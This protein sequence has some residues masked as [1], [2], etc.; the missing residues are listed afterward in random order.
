M[1]LAEAKEAF[2]A[3][4][5]TDKDQR[6]EAANLIAQACVK[7][8]DEEFTYVGK[9]L[10][11]GLV[12][13]VEGAR[14]G[15][16]VALGLSLRKLSLDATSVSALT[17]RD[18][19]LDALHRLYDLECLPAT[20]RPLKI[21]HPGGD[22]REL[23]LA[24]L[25]A[26]GS[27]I[28]ALVD[29]QHVLLPSL[30]LDG[31][32]S[33]LALIAEQEPKSL[34]EA[35]GR[36]ACE[37]VTR[38]VPDRQAFRSGT[39]S[40]DA[41]VRYWKRRQR[42][43]HPTTDALALVLHCRLR[44]GLQA[45][46]AD[47]A[48]W[49]SEPP[50]C[51]RDL[52]QSYVRPM[53]EDLVHTDPNLV[54]H[55]LAL[56][57]VDSVRCVVSSSERSA[58][59]KRPLRG[60]NHPAAWVHFYEHIV[61]PM[62]LCHTQYEFVIL[63][64]RL[65]VLALTQAAS[66]LTCQ[67]QDWGGLFARAEWNERLWN[68]PLRYKKHAAVI[69]PLMG[70]L[71]DAL[72]ELLRASHPLGTSLAVALLCSALSS[73]SGRA[74]RPP[75]IVLE[76][77]VSQ[78]KATEIDPIAKLAV[79]SHSMDLLLQLLST[80]VLGTHHRSNLEEFEKIGT[81]LDAV[82]EELSRAPHPSS[83]RER[84]EKMLIET[85]GMIASS[86]GIS[87]NSA[88]AD[89]LP[90]LRRLLQCLQKS[91]QHEPTKAFQACLAHLDG[92]G[93][94]QDADETVT[95][96]LALILLTTLT[97]LLW[98]S[99]SVPFNRTSQGRPDHPEKEIIIQSAESLSRFLEKK[100]AADHIESEQYIDLVHTCLRLLRLDDHGIRKLV[101]AVFGAALTLS[102][103]VASL[104]GPVLTELPGLDQNETSAEGESL[105]SCS[106][107][108]D[109]MISADAHSTE[110]TAS[111]V[112]WEARTEIPDLGADM[113]LDLDQEDPAVLTAYDKTL[114][115]A[116]GPMFSNQ[117][118][119]RPRADGQNTRSNIQYCQRVL[120]LIQVT[121]Q[122]QIRST[123]I[124]PILLLDMLSALN[125][126]TDY[127]EETYGPSS[128]LYQ[129]LVRNV[130][131]GM[132]R[133][134]AVG[135][136]GTPTHDDVFLDAF[137][138]LLRESV[139]MATLR[140]AQIRFPDHLPATLHAGI[141]LA[142]RTN[143]PNGA[144]L[145]AS[146]VA[147]ELIQPL[148]AHYRAARG[149]VTATLGKRSTGSVPLS[150]FLAFAQDLATRSPAVFTTPIIEALR[151]LLTSEL[152][153]QDATAPRLRAHAVLECWAVVLHLASA[154]PTAV[155]VDLEQRLNL[156]ELWICY[157]AQFPTIGSGQRKA[158]KIIHPFLQRLTK[159]ME[160][161]RARPVDPKLNAQ[162]YRLYHLAV[163]KLAV[164]EH[165][166]AEFLRQ[167]QQILALLSMEE[168]PHAPA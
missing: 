32:L 23:A 13:S 73:P 85:A 100:T 52:L 144:A 25:Y 103:D 75:R 131:G 81:L 51:S 117:L 67:T 151:A 66:T 12:S 46:E 130:L 138:I 165:S 135:Q 167:R 19:L 148:F 56:L 123:R 55:A 108:I 142:L 6:C 84:I 18:L 38:L 163:E 147:V 107:S 10:V 37:A 137:R 160:T 11:H 105:T 4:L 20:A 124:A 21:P 143:G 111:P 57:T 34:S 141:R 61:A 70:R 59:G 118:P 159:E 93:P 27:V 17:R 22:A 39:S 153:N 65:F 89:A 86:L 26:L 58:P 133:A 48:L 155:L 87:K 96:C 139:E 79:Q 127:I 77:S 110:N 125:H 3:L 82:I 162:L 158:L 49:G 9:R 54:P 122:Y 68:A 136:S 126:T 168:T 31:V 30:Q 91:L 74:V 36:L 28:G 35:C 134:A 132:Q 64:M 5:S 24:R 60:G 42:Q 95:E 50:C 88:A 120:D 43:G 94:K 44:F 119:K 116:L 40:R 29:S 157:L 115:T 99:E 98:R 63:G 161:Q 113:D 146:L 102:S 83:Q 149:R 106:E 47:C 69:E 112:F 129:R 76:A 15:F 7:L 80:R 2:W 72:L 140:P 152:E 145:V 16:S 128:E 71:I 8:S 121:I 114:A 78:L 104:V 150:A 41:V 109:S 14:E 53:V 156:I 90:R 92:A 1:A 33:A 154:M 164:A 45:S 166:P 97:V 101:K 62:L